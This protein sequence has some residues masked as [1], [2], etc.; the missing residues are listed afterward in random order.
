[1]GGNYPN[2]GYRNA[3]A[4]SLSGDGFQSFQGPQ[5][6]APP[7]VKPWEVGRPMAPGI[8]ANDNALRSA[9]D[10]FKIERSFGTRSLRSNTGRFIR[11]GMRSGKLLPWLGLALGALDAYEMYQRRFITQNWDFTGWTL[12]TQCILIGPISTVSPGSLNLCIQ[13]GYQPTLALDFATDANVWQAANAQK[14]RENTY[15][16]W[17]RA[18]ATGKPTPRTVSPYDPLPGVDPA[19]VPW[20]ALAPW[21]IPWGMLPLAPPRPIPWPLLPALK[22]FPGVPP[23]VQP[24]RGYA[25]PLGGPQPAGRPDPLPNTEYR[26]GRSARDTGLPH[27]PEPPGRGTKEGKLL[28]SIDGAALYGRLLNGATEFNDLVSAFY[29]AF[30]KGYKLLPTTWWRDPLGKWHKSGATM[31]EKIAFVY[32]HFTDINLR[33]A[34]RNVWVNEV[35]DTFYGRLGRANAAISRRLGLGANTPGTVLRK[36][37]R[38]V[39]SPLRGALN[40]AWDAMHPY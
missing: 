5:P 26:S 36:A 30:P 39:D 38:G 40:K 3:T 16:H 11:G 32:T 1:M 27:V 6:V 9:N 28:A 17:H 7:P 34:V 15:Q 2:G 35:I 20:P 23:Q 22:P 33:A 4:R 8:P 19:P 29:G 21:T 37:L 12:I 13:T 24:Q 10:N 14:T 31:Q 25:E 18:V